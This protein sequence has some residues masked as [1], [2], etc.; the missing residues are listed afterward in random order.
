MP[1]RMLTVKISIRVWKGTDAGINN[2]MPKQHARTLRSPWGYLKNMK[3]AEIHVWKLTTA[4]CE[5]GV[6][7]KMV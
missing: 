1:K 2:E 7:W 5:D 3:P 6:K 4:N